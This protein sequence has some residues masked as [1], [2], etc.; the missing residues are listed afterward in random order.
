MTLKPAL[1]TIILLSGSAC[2]ETVTQNA[3]AAMV[4]LGTEQQRDLGDCQRLASTA[5]VADPVKN[6]LKG[7]AL[8]ATI[9]AASAD[10]K[11]DR[12]GTALA[13]AALLGVVSA[14]RQKEEAKKAYD[15]IVMHCMIA[16]GHPV[17]S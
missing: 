8:G 9:G 15:S 10:R 3:Q 1:V 2:T 7:A 4:P 6:V 17:A 12:A 5:P 13:G 14:V 16:R 11:S